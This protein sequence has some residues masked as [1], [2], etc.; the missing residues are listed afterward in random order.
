MSH[1][2]E[3]KQI[4]DYTFEVSTLNFSDGMKVKAKADKL[5]MLKISDEGEFEE[6]VSPLSA[7]VFMD[8]D[9]DNLE[10]VIGK[11]AERSRV[12]QAGGSYLPLASQKELIFAGNYEL[13]YQ[14][15]DFAIEVTYS[16]FL[17]GLRK[18]AKKN[19]GKVKDS[20]FLKK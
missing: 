9:I 15:L 13:M 1:K 17:D 11:F 19:M 8:I 10:F 14:W 18:T 4:G 20:K 5:L 12:K 2:S 3:E 7:S 6:G 16:N